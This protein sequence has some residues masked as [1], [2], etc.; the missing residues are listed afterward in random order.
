METYNLLKN[1]LDMTA[2]YNLKEEDFSSFISELKTVY[3]KQ[4][5]IKAKPKAKKPYNWV[6]QHMRK[7][8]QHFRTKC[9]EWG[10]QNYLDLPILFDAVW[11]QHEEELDEMNYSKKQF[12]LDFA[13]DVAVIMTSE[14]YRRSY[15]FCEHCLVQMPS[16]KD[17]AS[18]F[19]LKGTEYHKNPETGKKE[20]KCFS[21]IAC[22]EG[23]DQL[24]DPH[25]TPFFH[26]FQDMDLYISQCAV[27]SKLF[28]QDPEKGLRQKD[29]EQF[30]QGGDTLQKMLPQLLKSPEEDEN[31]SEDVGSDE[32]N[33]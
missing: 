15:D 4:N 8:S 14:I 12:M 20:A 10:R 18:Y 11:E 16:F 1:G 3:K 21:K 29:A 22:S 33:D 17:L 24:V 9:G 23:I 31:S 2:I 5:Q 28:V 7:M 27:V 13:S 32:K 30:L 19:V 26:G 25:I 6:L